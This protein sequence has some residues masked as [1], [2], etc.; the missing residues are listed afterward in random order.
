MSDFTHIYYM[1]KLKACCKDAYGLLKTMET[2]LQ[3]MAA[4]WYAKYMLTPVKAKFNSTLASGLPWTLDINTE[5][6]EGAIIISVNGNII[7]ILRGGDDGLFAVPKGTIVDWS[8]LLEFGIKLKVRF[9]DELAKFFHNHQISKLGATI[10]LVKT[11]H[12]VISRKNTN[13]CY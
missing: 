10:P 8:R 6:V 13:N 2:S 11:F 1:G 3:R 12:K 5:L 9:V 7:A 4:E